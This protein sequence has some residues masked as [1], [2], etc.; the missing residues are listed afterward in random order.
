MRKLRRIGSLA[1]FFL[2]ACAAGQIGP[3]PIEDGDACSF[4]RMAIS[5]RQFAAEIIKADEAVL[6]FDDIACM[7]RYQARSEDK[8]EPAA[9]FVTDY[10]SKEWI[11]AED[12]HFMRSETIKT[13]MG[14]G[15]IAYRDRSKIQGDSLR[16]GDLKP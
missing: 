15:I 4:C 5:E 10:D 3:V 16:F 12:A 11:R 6:K 13:P 14:G 8:S 1:L 2:A 9:I 7:L